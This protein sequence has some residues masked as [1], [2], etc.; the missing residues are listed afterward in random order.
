MDLFHTYCQE[1][2]Q[3]AHCK[4]FNWQDHHGLW[5]VRLFCPRCWNLWK[6]LMARG[7]KPE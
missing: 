7:V 6:L 5:N 4:P 3:K 2:R 1:C